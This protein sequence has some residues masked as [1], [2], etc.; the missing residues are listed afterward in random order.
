MNI[1]KENTGDLSALLKVEVT[2]SDYEEKVDKVLRNYRKKANIKGF[3]PG[4]VPIGMIKKMYGNAVKLDEIN[5]LVSESVSGYL[6]EQNIEILGDPLPADNDDISANFE[7]RED[8]LFTFE[9]GL[10][11]SFEVKLSKKDKV[12][13]YEISI[14][15]KLRNDYLNNY[16]RKYGEFKDVETSE[17]SD[18]LKGSISPAGNPG[19][20]GIPFYNADDVTLSV[21]IIKDEEIKKEFTGKKR[22]D[23]V[24]FD[25]K[26]AFPNDYEIAG[27]LKITREQAVK[28]EGIYRF[29]INGISRFEPA[30]V[31]QELFDKIYGEGVVNSEEEFYDKIT[32]E[33]SASLANESNDKLSLSLKKLALEKITFSLPEDFLKKWLLKVN[34]KTTTEQ[35]EK[36]FES[37]SKDLRWQLIRKKIARENE[38]KITEEEML[39][40]AE[41]ITAY[42]FRQYGL[43]YVPQEQIT[44]YAHEMLKREEDAQRIADRILEDKAIG[45]IKE[46]VTLENK[47]VTSEEFN[48]L[49]EE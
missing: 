17:E 4:M 34:E 40:E 12:P 1:T 35:I 11:P 14:D 5:K 46:M 19:D 22:G 20:A 45:K 48:K 37:F 6:R 41:S 27:L 26:K 7:T 21:S 2:K 24:D 36:E 32:G 3:R 49:F 25:I 47:K 10:A 30:Q 18:M 16:T 23:T 43:L 29:T 15:E 33:I 44:N 38:I 42:Q 28:V 13:Y 31:G 9:L 39:H 8:F